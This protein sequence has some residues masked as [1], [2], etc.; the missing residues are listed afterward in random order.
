M[1]ASS[2]FSYRLFTIPPTG[3][4]NAIAFTCDESLRWWVERP[5]K[6]TICVIHFGFLELAT[7]LF[8]FIPPFSPSFSQCTTL[9]IRIVIAS[10]F[11]SFFAGGIC[12]TT[13][14]KHGRCTD[15]LSE[16]ITKEECCRDFSNV[17]TAWSKED[18]DSGKLFFLRVLGD[19]VPCHSCK[20]NTFVYI[21]AFSL[22]SPFR[23]QNTFLLYF[24]FFF[25]F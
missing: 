9:V 2:C 22:W 14:N 13:V 23:L 16:K 7:F 18:M 1:Y 21:C 3:R 25:M 12:W 17:N 4:L 11:V 10:R 6:P 19:G 8:A 24:H 15:I 5:T 20:G